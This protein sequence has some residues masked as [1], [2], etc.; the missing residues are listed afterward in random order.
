MASRACAMALSRFFQ[1]RGASFLRV[2][3]LRRGL[4]DGSEV[5]RVCGQENDSGPLVLDGASEADIAMNAKV[6]PAHDVAWLEFRCQTVLNPL[7]H[8]AKG[9]PNRCVADSAAAMTRE[10]SDQGVKRRIGPPLGRQNFLPQSK[11]IGHHTPFVASPRQS[12]LRYQRPRDVPTQALQLGAIAAID[13]L[14]VTE[15]PSGDVISLK[16]GCPSRSPLTAM[17]RAPAS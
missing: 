8:A 5:R 6:V 13:N 17:P 14:S 11:R 2:L 4:L 1:R 16:V 7:E 9:A 12:V 10:Q 15:L 3:C